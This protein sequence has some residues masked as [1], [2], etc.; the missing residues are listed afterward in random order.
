MMADVMTDQTAI[1]LQWRYPAPPERVF[2]AWTEPEILKEWFVPSAAWQVP[3]AEIDLRPGGRY[4]IV[5]KAPNGE[6]HEGGGTYRE[7]SPP[8]KL[9]FTW[10]WGFTQDKESLVTVEL[11]ESEGGTSLLLTHE[12]LAPERR[13][14]HLDGWTKSLA[15]LAQLEL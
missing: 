14:P 3:I 9:V 12:R 15:R 5:M 11:R 2:R 7:V 10:A 6:G 13:E 1:V 4:R 8:G